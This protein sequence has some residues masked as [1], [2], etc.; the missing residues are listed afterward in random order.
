VIDDRQPV[1][2]A[3][4]MAIERDE[5]VSPVDLMQRACEIALAKAPRLRD[6]IKSISVVK[7]VTGSDPAPASSLSKSLGIPGARC[8]TTTVGGN[9]PQWLV[10]RLSDS[11]WAGEL[12]VALIC[13]GEAQRSDWIEKRPARPVNSDGRANSDGPDGPDRVVGDDRL[14]FGDAELGAGLLAPAQVYPLFESVIADEAGRTMAEHRRFLG[15]LLAPMTKVAAAHRTAWFPIPRTPEEIAE[16]SPEN[17]LVSEPYTKLMC[18]FPGVDQGASVVICSFGAARA[19]GLADAAV[20]CRSGADISEVW[21]PTARP[22]LGGLR[23]LREA[24]SAAFGAAGLGVDEV[25]H[26]D[27]YSCFPCAVEMAAGAIGLGV[28]DPR[29]VTVTG[30]LPYF[31]GPWNC[32]TLFAIATITEMLR[33]AGSD[34]PVTGFV[35]GIG[36]YATKHSVGVYGSTPTKAGWQRVLTEDLQAENDGAALPVSLESPREDAEATVRA[37]GVVYGKGGEVTAAPVIA[38]LEDGTRLAASPADSVDL[39]GLAGCN[40]TG[41]RIHLAGSPPRY[42][43]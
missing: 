13:G 20:F 18:A 37:S 15:G 6:R 25:D 2:V 5:L 11:I 40:L 3:S 29:G 34:S 30:G 43:L 22:E 12:E 35:N 42:R 28:E 23:A 19:A 7:V 4:G 17:R 24:S 8:E 39:D 31:G 38:S 9:S 1:I 36:W 27:L 10:S 21:S 32:Y 16:P 14:G 41:L 26:F 33:S